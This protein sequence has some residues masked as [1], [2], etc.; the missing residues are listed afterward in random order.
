MAPMRLATGADG[1]VAVTGF[2]GCWVGADPETSNAGPDYAWLPVQTAVGMVN[3]AAG[4]GGSGAAAVIDAAGTLR[5]LQFGLPDGM[6]QPVCVHGG[7]IFTVAPPPERLP[8]TPRAAALHARTGWLV[9]ACGDGRA[10][11]AVHGGGA[12]AVVDP[13]TGCVEHVVPL[14]PGER[15]IALAC[16]ALAPYGSTTAAIAAGAPPGVAPG[17]EGEEVVAIGIAR[18]PS[19]AAPAPVGAVG[20]VS[21][22][23]DAYEIA[24]Y[25]VEGPHLVLAYRVRSCVYCVCTLVSC[26]YTLCVSVSR[27]DGRACLNL[28]VTSR[29]RTDRGGRPAARDVRFWDPANRWFRCGCGWFAGLCVCVCL[30]LCTFMFVF[31]WRVCL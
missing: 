21:A 30:R 18:Y 28:A 8:F 17:A 1:Y 29:L 7:S 11:D 31:M 6:T 2:G 26:A 19:S 20:V 4:A 3:S 5:L 13:A 15:P 9:V 27:G 10:G 24:V 14:G 22:P 16:G 23:P 25:R 12:V